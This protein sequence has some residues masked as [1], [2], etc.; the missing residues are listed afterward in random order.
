M[1]RRSGS[2]DR[3][4]GQVAG[5]VAGLSCPTRATDWTG[6]LRTEAPAVQAACLPVELEAQAE[7]LVLSAL[8]AMAETSDLLED[9][10]G[11]VLRDRRQ[12]LAW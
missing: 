4:D 9:R 10:G 5:Q 3:L 12:R 8:E 2:R 6:W 11:S 1:V 7:L